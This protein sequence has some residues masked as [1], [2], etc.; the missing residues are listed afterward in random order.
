MGSFVDI[1]LNIFRRISAEQK[2]KELRW[3]LQECL[4]RGLSLSA[5]CLAEL[6]TS[7]DRKLG[8]GAGHVEEPFSCVFREDLSLYLYAK[9]LFDCREYQRAAAVLQSCTEVRCRFLRWYALF[10]HGEKRK[11]E[12]FL[13]SGAGNFSG[14]RGSQNAQ[15]TVILR[16]IDNASRADATL[17]EDAYISWI[18]GI[19]LK[20]CGSERE[21][22][23]A[24]IG[25]LER[26][27]YLWAAWVELHELGQDFSAVAS[28]LQPVLER[29]D[30]W[31]F[32]FFLTMQAGTSVGNS[33][34]ISVLEELSAEF[35]DS[36]TLM[37]QLAQAYFS[38]HD[39]E[40]AAEH[41]R[42]VRELDPCCLDG[43]DLFSNILFVQEDRVE[44]SAL[45]QDCVRI[46]KYRAETCC[47]VGNYF[48]LRQNHE[49]AVQYF[50]RALALNRSYVAAWTL[51]GHEF[52][53][54]RNTSAAVEAYR[55]AIDLDPRDFR[56]FYGLGQTYELL[57]MPHY[58]L[59]YF[60][61]AASL[62]PCDDRMWVAMSQVLQDLGRVEDSIRCLEK[63]LTCNP[64]NW[65]CAKRA[66]D[67]LWQLG[68]FD[69]AA[70]HYES[71][72]KVRKA[73][74]QP[75]VGLDSE[76]TDIVIRMAAYHM[77]RGEY[78]VANEYV[79]MQSDVD[80]AEKRDI[81]QGIKAELSGKCP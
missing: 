45:A 52:L 79:D 17:F 81:L 2:R 63:A 16:E 18:R 3:A 69:S 72:V 25:A 56:P 80:N 34:I 39:F 8:T 9:T 40:T 59:Y 53:E 32:A 11:E 21:A 20:A 77:K 44:L 74:K 14:E 68:H 51:M 67:L 65:N 28:A 10:L 38:A 31:M 22:M 62:R 50:R 76:E 57:H 64:E 15:A 35:T 66:G 12:E 70:K 43:V 19:A 75:F 78:Q 5:R 58:A 37:Q 42:R 41:C 61:K 60:E 55:R 71:Y 46:D 54:M 7:L 13:Q 27:R 30:S 36:V 33:I 47:V 1:A 73:L 23:E 6:L 26:K 29:G 24:F 48:A 49:K 4:E